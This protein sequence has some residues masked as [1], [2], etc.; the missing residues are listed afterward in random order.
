MH[1]INPAGAQLTSRS[2]EVELATGDRPL[3]LRIGHSSRPAHGKFNEDCY[4]IVT[5]AQE[6]EATVRGSAIAIV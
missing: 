6:P 4:G 5:P 1:A 3:L 2:I